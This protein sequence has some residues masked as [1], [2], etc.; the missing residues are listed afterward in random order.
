M[1][2]TSDEI[3]IVYPERYGDAQDVRIGGVASAF[4]IPN[5]TGSPMSATQ[6]FAFAVY[7]GGTYIQYQKIFITNNSDEDATGFMLYG[8]N[9]N[10]NSIMSM[11]VESDHTGMV[12][13]G[14][15]TTKNIYTRPHNLF[16]YST[17][18]EV[19]HDTGLAVDIPAGKSLGVWLKLEFASIGTDNIN[20][21]FRI[22]YRNSSSTVDK[23]VDLVHSRLDSSVDIIN[24]AKTDTLVNGIMV[25]YKKIDTS[26][27]GIEIEDAVYGV[28][29][30]RVFH[31]ETSGGC[32][33]P[34]TTYGN[35]IP[36]LIELFLLPYS[37]YRPVLQPVPSDY[38]NRLKVVFESVDSDL[39]EVSK[40]LI[41]WD[42]ATGTYQPKR[43]GD[44]NVLTGSG[45]GSQIDYCITN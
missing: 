33:V 3:L 24:W 27:M 29:V 11:A 35:D 8:Y 40:Y 15:E 19:L 17:W 22:G 37:G 1:A 42:N 30:D 38:K 31:G 14:S 4:E 28:F 45:G 20:D 41:F 7:Y 44:I 32:R 43:I 39:N 9:I 5:Y 23:Y 25:E 2:I 18:I 12:F 26:A 13:D 16:N 6:L 10:D 21:V 36:L 34:V